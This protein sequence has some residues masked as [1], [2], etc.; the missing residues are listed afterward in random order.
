MRREKGSLL[1]VPVGSLI[2]NPTNFFPLSETISNQVYSKLL[3]ASTEDVSSSVFQK[4]KCKNLKL[5][6]LIMIR[7]MNYIQV[8]NI[9]EC[10]RT[11]LKFELSDNPDSPQNCYIEQALDELSKREGE[12]LQRVKLNEIDSFTS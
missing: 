1:A 7:V 5:S 12:L 8:M 6:M 11:Q 2:Q 10:E 4:S 3:I 9:I